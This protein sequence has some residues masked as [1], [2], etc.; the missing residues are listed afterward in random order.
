MPALF[1]CAEHDESFTA[2]NCE[3]SEKLLKERK[4]KGTGPDYEFKVYPKTEHG[5]ATRGDAS[6]PDIKFA[7]DDHYK[8]TVEF[9]QKYL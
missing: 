2:A 4:E 3:A 1:L 6:K 7:M 9:Y 8:R 5:F